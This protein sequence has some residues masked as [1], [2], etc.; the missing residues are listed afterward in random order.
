M[1]RL[2]ALAPEEELE[3]IALDEA[4]SEAETCV[5]QAGDRILHDLGEDEGVVHELGQRRRVVEEVVGVGGIEGLV[6]LVAE[7]LS[8]SISISSIS[9][10]S[11]SST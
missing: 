6:L 10:S 8:I 11:R 1:A 9:I 4:T 7:H 2:D 5:L 3:L